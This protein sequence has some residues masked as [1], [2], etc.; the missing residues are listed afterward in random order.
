MAQAWLLEPAISFIQFPEG[1]SA[2]L[3]DSSSGKPGQGMQVSGVTMPLLSVQGAKI[4][5][6]FSEVPSGGSSSS[7]GFSGG[8]GSGACGVLGFRS[9]SSSGEMTTSESFL[10]MFEVEATS[11]AV[12]AKA[13]Y[14]HS[15][16][17]SH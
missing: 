2:A 6:G 5:L 11:L 14:N 4:I 7:S 9:V 3:T 8:V 15:R 10:S 1:Q 13:L 16:A 12:E 17:S